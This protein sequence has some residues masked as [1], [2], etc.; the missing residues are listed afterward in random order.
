M[1]WDVTCITSTKPL[2]NQKI[3]NCVKTL[4][5][6]DVYTVE[7]LLEMTEN[8]YVDMGLGRALVRT[9]LRKAREAV[10]QASS[11]S[12]TLAKSDTLMLIPMEH[13]LDAEFQSPV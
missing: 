6:N 2:F 5:D 3:S 1:D 8:D 4:D 9:M 11:S 10:V 13:S 12:A 7:M